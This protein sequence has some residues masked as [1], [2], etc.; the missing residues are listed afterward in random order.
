MSAN[1]PVNRLACAGID[2]RALNPFAWYRRRKWSKQYNGNPIYQIAN[3]M[4]ATAL[5]LAAIAKSEGDISAE[6]K[7]ELLTIFE[8][9]FHLSKKGASEL[10]VATTHML[11]DGQEAIKNV[12][13]DSSTTIVPVTG[14]MTNSDAR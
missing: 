1:T 2:L 7:R 4:E 13:T 11:G 12:A 14:W 6:Q 8:K 10:L 9:E 3:P 5:L